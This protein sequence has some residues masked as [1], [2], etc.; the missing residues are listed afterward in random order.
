MA[1]LNNRYNIIKTLGKGGF[2]QTFLAV[3][4]HLPS[5]RSCVIKQLKPLAAKPSQKQWLEDRFQQE[6]AILEKLGENNDQI[7][8]L[9]AYFSENGE[10]YLVQ[11]YIE[12]LTLT[13]KV[14][15]Q[16]PLAV[17]EV[18]Q[19]LISLLRV[20][21][22]VHQQQKIHRDIKP[23]N[24]ILRSRD[25]KPVLIDFGAVKEAVNTAMQSGDNPSVAIGT[26][27]FM[28]SEQAAGRPMYSSDLYSLGL[29]AIFLLSGKLPQQL[30][31]DAQSGEIMWR[32]AVPNLPANLDTAIDRAIRYHPRDR[33]TSASEMLQALSSQGSPDSVAAT[34]VVAP[35]QPLATASPPSTPQPTVAVT[36]SPPT[37]SSPKRGLVVAAAGLLT[38]VGIGFLGYGL[39]A[40]KQ[41]TEPE[42]VL[43]P[44]PSPSVSPTTPTPLPSASPSPSPSPSASPSPTPTPSPTPSPSP[45]PSPSPPP[46]PPGNVPVPIFPLGT[47][48]SEVIQALGEPTYNRKGYF[49][50]TRAVA[51]EDYGEEISLGF[52]FDSETGRLRQSEVSFDSTVAIAP[53][54]TTLTALLG[55][56]LPEV[57]RQSLAAVYN[58][59]TDLR[60]FSA[61]DLQGLIQRNRRDRI[62][63]AVWE[64][65][66][67]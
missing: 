56:Q 11:E 9:Y 39:F 63:M 22:Y 24:V 1:L 37:A 46:S 30:T 65:S 59:Q 31:T 32:E 62:Y 8:Q 26:P 15:Q 33:Y 21:E 45:S 10:F 34:L 7:P 66:F 47:S 38:L 29:T 20:L 2:G 40:P 55:N 57:P 35:G 17:T 14:Q 19:L 5:Q 23:D 60:S 44:S 49:P 64:R 50:N 54:E 13:Q 53:I 58:R 42:V 43:S 27:G 61:G 36:P 41:D 51:Y 28:A 3:D 67:R 16:G 52:I 25:N 18:E 12:G 4:T 6:A 48:Q